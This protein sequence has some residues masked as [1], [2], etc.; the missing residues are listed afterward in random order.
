MQRTSNPQTVGSIPTEGAERKKMKIGDLV[1][2]RDPSRAEWL[3]E[4]PLDYGCVGII[5]DVYETEVYPQYE[6]R[7][8]H[9]RSWFDS[10]QLEV[11]SDITNG[12]IKDV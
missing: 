11:L 3:Q 8:G 4:Y 5:I 10:I 6:V 1:R 9:E 2:L 7:F 12:V